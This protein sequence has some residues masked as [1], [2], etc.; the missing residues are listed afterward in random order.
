MQGLLPSSCHT[1]ITSSR[2]LRGRE[3]QAPPQ[4][5][6]RRPADEP[7]DWLRSK[8]GTAGAVCAKQGNARQGEQRFSRG[9]VM[10]EN[11]PSC[12]II[13]SSFTWFYTLYPPLG[14]A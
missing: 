11:L 13:P 2:S 7:Q 4:S 8:H 1:A 9:A 5:G 6:A 10:Q 3:T 14:C 12:K